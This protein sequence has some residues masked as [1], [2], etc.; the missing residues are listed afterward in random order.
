MREAHLTIPELAL[1]AG[2]RAL[3]GMGIGLL[4][5]DRFPESARKSVG[6]TLVLAGAATTIPLAFEIL[7][8]SESTNQSV[9][10]R[11]ARYAT[12]AYYG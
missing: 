3:I 9:P 2:T 6:W 7:S 1:V 12:P 4:V 5:A 8:K 10:S 11:P